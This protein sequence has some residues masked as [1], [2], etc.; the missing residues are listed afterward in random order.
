MAMEEKVVRY[1]LTRK[2]L[3]A[4]QFHALMR[5]RTLQGMTILFMLFFMCQMY[6]TPPP[7]GQPEHPLGMKIAVA[8][9]GGLMALLVMFVFMFLI[10]FLMVR[11]NKFKGLLGEHVLTLTDAGMS[12][13]SPHTES[14]RKWT[15]LL[16]LASTNKHLFLYVNET[17]AQIVPKRYFASPAEAQSFERVIWERKRTS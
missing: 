5:N 9:V 4:F 2:D 13:R 6:N 15:G 12:T 1:T 16:K 8:I 10:I 17:S 7:Q 11:T 14:S 3:F